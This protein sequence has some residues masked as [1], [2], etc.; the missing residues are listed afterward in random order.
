V[1]VLL[2]VAP[3]W[4]V[5]PVGFGGGGIALLLDNEECHHGH[6]LDYCEEKDVEIYDLAIVGGAGLEA[7]LPTGVITADVRYWHGVVDVKY[8][9]GGDV[10]DRMRALTLSV[11]YAYGW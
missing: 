5:R 11:G 10:R 1:P 6:D 7:D 8:G 2:R 9:D 4:R 3:R